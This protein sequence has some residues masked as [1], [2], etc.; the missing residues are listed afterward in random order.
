MADEKKKIPASVTI[1]AIPILIFFAIFFAVPS[2]SEDLFGISIRKTAYEEGV[3]NAN[4][5][6]SLES[7]RKSDVGTDEDTL[8]ATESE[9]NINAKNAKDTSSERTSASAEGKTES[10]SFSLSDPNEKVGK[11][12]SQ[13]GNR[14]NELTVSEEAKKKAYDFLNDLNTQI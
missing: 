8:K 7:M 12:A 1:A 2:V 9:P 4:A 10:K 3:R 13:I 14:I 11:A 6:N 5:E